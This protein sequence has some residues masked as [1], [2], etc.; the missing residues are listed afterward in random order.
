M[1]DRVDLHQEI[2]DCIVAA[3]EAG[4]TSS[5][6]PWVGA[7]QALPLRVTGEGYRGINTLLLWLAAQERGYASPTWMTFKQALELGGAV[8]KG[9]KASR[10]VFFKTLEV[11]R[12]GRDEPDHIPMLRS[13]AVFNV[14][15]IDGLPD[16]FQPAP[17]P[18]LPAPARDAAAEAALRA[19]G[20][21]IHE[22]GN[23]AYYDQL[24]DAITLPAHDRFHSAELFC[25]T[26]AHELCHWT[27][28]KHRL[29][30]LSAAPFGSPAYAREELV[31][32]LGAAFV[33]GRL[34]IAPGH[35]D[36]HAA[37]LGSWLKALK[38]DKRA[39]FRAAADAQR[40]ADLV[41]AGAGAAD[42]VGPR[43]ATPVPAA[44]AAAPIA[45]RVA[46]QLAGPKRADPG[47]VVRDQAD[48][49]HL[50]LFVAANEPRLL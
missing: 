18:A 41:L 40:A 2:T 21:T 24:A 31:A 20:A 36:D 39:I 1:T 13:Y 46:L 35:I 16:R 45:E 33:C 32:E 7:S 19:T 5:G 11:E 47:A 12:D 43:N 26:L 3:L 28:A 29:D 10:V 42:R 49:A 30:R 34:G 48:A 23:A 14:D 17:L 4:A 27:G 25:A 44:A 22:G 6:P 8:R 50:P 9:E 15:Q 37:Y 38:E